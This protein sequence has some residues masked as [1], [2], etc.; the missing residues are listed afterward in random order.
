MLFLKERKNSFL[1]ILLSFPVINTSLFSGKKRKMSIWYSY[2]IYGSLSRK[3]SDLDWML[4]KVT[5]DKWAC[6]TGMEK[7]GSLYWE[8]HGIARDSQ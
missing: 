3:I 2:R 1:L 6:H 7:V 8:E 4:T 5:N